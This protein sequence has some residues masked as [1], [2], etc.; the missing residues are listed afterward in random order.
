[1]NA[2]GKSGFSEGENW[3]NDWE[4]DDEEN[5]SGFD[6][7]GNKWTRKVEGDELVQY[8]DGSVYFFDHQIFQPYY[9]DTIFWYCFNFDYWEFQKCS[10]V[11]Q[12]DFA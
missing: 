7:E 2:T 6:K 9:Y 10:V 1:M 11:P 12:L 5:C 3:R 8:Y 4:C